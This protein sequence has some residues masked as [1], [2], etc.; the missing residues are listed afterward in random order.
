MTDLGTYTFLPWLR[1]GMATQIK[2]PDGSTGGPLRASATVE[3]SFSPGNLKPDEPARINLFGSGDVVGLDPNAVLRTWPAPEVFEAESNY[4][5]FVEFNQPDLP[6]R[7]TPAAAAGNDRLRPWLCLVTIA[8]GQFVLDPPAGGGKLPLLRTDATNLPPLVDSWAWAHVQAVGLTSADAAAVGELLKTRPHQVISRILCPRRLTPRTSYTC[9]LV[10]TFEAGRRAGVGEAFDSTFDGLAPAWNDKSTA[11][12]LPVYFSWR[13]ATGGQGDFET[14]VRRLQPRAITGAGQRDM[15]VRGPGAALPAAASSPLA[16][17][18]A[19]MS[20]NTKP[21]VWKVEEKEAWVAPLARLLNR[22]SVRLR[23]PRADREIVPPLYGRWH[24]AK[25]SL[26][27]TVSAT[28]PWFEELN[29]DPRLRTAAGLGSLVVQD[30][31]ESLLAAAWEQVERIRAINDE[32][33]YAQLAR[34][35]VTSL[36]ERHTAPN[37]LDDL[38]LTTAPVHGRVKS[39]KGGSVEARLAASPIPAG[40]FDAA[41]RRIGRRRGSAGLTQGRADKPPMTGLLERLNRGSLSPAPPPPPPVG[42]NP[43]SDVLGAPG[44]L[45]PVGP[46]PPQCRPYEPFPKPNRDWDW[47]PPFDAQLPPPPVKLPGQ[48]PFPDAGGRVIEKIQAEPEPDV[49]VSV[50]LGEIRD[51]ILKSLDPKETIEKPLRERLR[52]PAGWKPEDPIE[53]IMAAPEFPQ[54]MYAPLRDLSNDWL[55]PGLD[56]V[57]PNTLCLLTTN[58]KFVEAYMTGLNYEMARA[59]LFDEYPTDQRGS[60]FRQFWDVRG[61]IG[62][63][64]PEQLKDIRQIHTWPQTAPLGKNNARGGSDHL[65]LLVRGD[66]LY[67]YPNTV[68][69][70]AKAKV[71]PDGKRE[72][73]ISDEKHPL[74]FG[75]MRPDVAFFGF[76]LTEEAARGSTGDPGWFFVLQEQP[77]EP[78]FGLDDVDD[79]KT[80]PPVP[81]DLAW[82][83][84]GDLS[85]MAY[86]PFGNLPAI[87]D[88]RPAQWPQ[89]RASDVAFVTL[90]RPYRV[91]IHAT[92]MLPNA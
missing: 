15:D 87:E 78:R 71:G 73:D 72:P 64:S 33:R 55:F 81:D 46:L 80:P 3:V 32:L 56:R 63:A 61:Y 75:S 88:P 67:R 41:W 1:R 12:I 23:D 37:T 5:P 19:L 65:V 59:L 79:P 31:R 91:A 39:S 6:W 21:S 28:Q 84:F 50:D 60:Y 26:P 44:T 83:H 54:P 22:A 40:I 58:G 13:F 10:P 34:E 9:F 53:P 20:T 17:P 69:Y 86:L 66:L 48:E 89:A 52:C 82:S 42:I 49:R 16:L 4:F 47:F 8:D 77:A 76:D 45:P 14:L 85:R 68:V 57:P 27:E 62:P 38:L 43:P 36:L 92:E 29:S 35:T 24:A 2:R 25:D 11:C 7:Y 18:G 51:D 90:R 70:A 30:Q 74:F